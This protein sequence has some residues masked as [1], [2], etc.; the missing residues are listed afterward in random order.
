VTVRI[1]PH[2]RERAS[3]RGAAEDE[4]V[5]TVESG[6]QVPAKL[7]RT[8]FRRDFSFG[9]TWRG[10]QYDTKQIEAYAVREDG[11]WLVITVIVKFF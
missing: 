5:E 11:G 10:R 8:G 1:H 3:E 2:A 4:I 7:G 6:I 9:K